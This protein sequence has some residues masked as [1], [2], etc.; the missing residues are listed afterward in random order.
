MLLFYFVAPVWVL[1]HTIAD[2]A[3]FEQLN[4]WPPIFPL[5]PPQSPGTHHAYRSHGSGFCILNDLAVT[6]EVLLSEGKVERV[7]IL[8]LDV[9]QV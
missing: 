2:C 1:C 5:H 4:G 8:D 9:H 6:A 3:D 7:L